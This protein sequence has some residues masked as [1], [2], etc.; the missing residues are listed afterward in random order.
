MRLGPGRVVQTMKVLLV[1]EYP[2]LHGGERS[3]LAAVRAM[4]KRGV[5]WQAIAPAEGPLATALR[6]QNIP[7]TAWPTVERASRQPQLRDFLSHVLPQLLPDLIHANSLSMARV[8]GPVA[9]DLAIPAIGHLRDIMKVSAKAAEDLNRMSRLVAVS[10]AVRQYHIAQGL[11]PHR[12]TVIPNGVDAS[13][14]APRPANG[15]L[16]QELKIPPGTPLI[17][18]IGQ[19]GMRK[20][21]DVLLAALRIVFAKDP[22][23]HALLVGEQS[24]QKLEADRY[25]TSLR[26]TA[27]DGVLSNRVHFLGCR[28]DVP[29]LL[30]ELTMLVHPAR[31]EPLGRVLLESAAA[32]VPIVATH[33]GGTPEIFPPGNGAAQLVPPDNPA[34]LASA[35]CRLLADEALCQQMAV[36]A[37]CRIESAFS[38]QRCSDAT[39]CL[40][41]RVSCE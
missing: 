12:L 34:L 5:R 7:V 40:Y 13:E 28:T 3:M 9:H 14:F 11:D 20:G 32:G 35:I 24:S 18:G 29:A 17:G 27:D 6:Q 23:T 38:D 4:A 10:Q 31:Q 33:V 25:V 30:S 22:H 8:V 1:F 19:L 41:D 2:T 39:W 37:R 16:H 26:A 36:A 21:W 15:Y